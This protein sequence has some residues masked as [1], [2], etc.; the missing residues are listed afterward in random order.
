MAW[1]MPAWTPE[2]IATVASAIAALIGAVA[3]IVSAIFAGIAVRAQRRAQ[4]PHIR[5]THGSPMPVF[6][7]VGR[8]LDGSR[9][10]EPWFTITVH[11]DGL[12]PVT[13]RSVALILNDRGSAPYLRPPWPGGDVLGATIAPGEEA[14]YFLD[15]L[16]KIAQ[17]HAEHGG[18]KWA[19]ATIGGNAEFHGKHIDRRWLD[20]W[21]RPRPT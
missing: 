7:G 17:V 13:V 18:A 19:K 6:G 5:V 3:A 9:V 4:R 1:P 12:M 16:R 20:G 2:Q 11:N 8:Y 14:T 21:A 15:E 10:G